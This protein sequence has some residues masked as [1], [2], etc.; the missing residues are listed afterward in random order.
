[1]KLRKFAALAMGACMVAFA[2]PGIAQETPGVTDTSVTVGGWMPLSGPTAIYGTPLKAGTEAYFGLVNERGGVNGRKI[3][4]I[5][6]DN[7][8]S[9]QQT[10]SIARKL[11]SRDNVL[12]ILNAH[13]TAATAATF[14]YVLDQQKVPLLS[15]YGGAMDWFNPPKAGLFGLLALYEDQG[16]AVGRWAAEDG[17]K[18]I[19]VI[20]HSGQSF[21]VVAQNIVAGIKAVNADAELGSVSVKLG[22]TDYAPIAL[23]VMNF[24]PDAIVTIQIQQELVTLAEELKRQ[25]KTV[26]MY[27]YAPTT[28]YSL[29]ELGGDVVDGVKSI[30]LTVSPFA[31]TPQ[32]QEYRDALAK[33]A[34][35]EKPDFPSLWTFGMAKVFVEALSRVEGSVTREK[36]TEAY[37]SLKDYDTGIFP[38]VTFAKDRMLGVS[39]MMRMQ[40]TGGEWKPMSDW[41]EPTSA[42]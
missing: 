38:P 29:A 42:Q 10:V 37:L 19:M 12:A 4:W 18:R 15:P 5:V 7:Q 26:P 28:L 30:S 39:K 2:N 41:L 11:I 20:Q 22:T 1:M 33:Y 13:G 21:D 14:P 17:H 9:T 25:G 27:L 16:Q 23:E 34:P 3:S 6:E 31:D 8:Y 40:L 36:L 32:V 35:G 24:N